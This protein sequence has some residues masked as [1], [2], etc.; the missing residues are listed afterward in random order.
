MRA[1]NP[2]L[3]AS[4]LPLAGFWKETPIIKLEVHS[5]CHAT[6]CQQ[7]MDDDSHN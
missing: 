7:G 6:A 1:E 2:F 3:T 5:Y 4:A